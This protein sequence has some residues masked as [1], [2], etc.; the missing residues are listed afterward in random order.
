MTDVS[1]KQ[2]KFLSD[3]ILFKLC[4][5]HENSKEIYQILKIAKQL[6]EE[7]KTP[8]FLSQEQIQKI[9]NLKYKLSI[10]SDK[11]LGISNI[12]QENGKVKVTTSSG[13]ILKF[14]IKSANFNF[15]NENANV[16]FIKDENNKEYIAYN[17]MIIENKE[18]RNVD[19]T[20]QFLQDYKVHNEEQ[21]TVY[22]KLVNIFPI[23]ITDKNGNC[24]I[25]SAFNPSSTQKDYEF[26]ANQLDTLIQ[27]NELS[28]ES[29]LKL[30]P[31]YALL[32]ISPISNDKI[33]F[34]ISAEWKSEDGSDIKFRIHSANEDFPI[35]VN[36]K[37]TGNWIFRFSCKEPDNNPDNNSEDNTYYEPKGTTARRNS[38]NAFVGNFAGDGSEDSHVSL[39]IQPNQGLL[40]DF[41]F[42]KVIKEI[43]RNI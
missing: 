24:I 33:N 4:T 35:I 28:A 31:R 42:Q 43:S 30:I 2:V 21:A 37:P 26:I 12:V 38:A 14:S 29:I 5:S 3:E 13:E 19:L 16:L 15:N 11:T 40:N 1:Y 27:N 10:N 18:Q 7:E 22:S 32:S 34:S 9:N 41:T 6:K 23:D 36:D 8:Y 17:G 39:Q 25:G 20:M